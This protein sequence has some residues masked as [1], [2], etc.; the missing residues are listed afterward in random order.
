MFGGPIGADKVLV[1]SELTGDGSHS[2]RAYTPEEYKLALLSPRGALETLLGP[3][4]RQWAP[5]IPSIL[6]LLLYFLY[7][8][9]RASCAKRG[10]ICSD[11]GPRR[12]PLEL[13][14]V[15]PSSRSPRR[16]RYPGCRRYLRG[17]IGVAQS[18]EGFDIGVELRVAERPIEFQSEC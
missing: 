11:I 10:P 15:Y 9:G 14:E 16:Y 6:S 2:G 4:W 5:M 7:Q 1:P 17:C 13:P 18:G 12:A 8:H 3:G